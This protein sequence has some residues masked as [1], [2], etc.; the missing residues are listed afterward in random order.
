MN[1]VQM[2]GYRIIL[3]CGGGARAHICTCSRSNWGAQEGIVKCAPIDV[4]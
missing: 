2:M 4:I 3:C 1:V